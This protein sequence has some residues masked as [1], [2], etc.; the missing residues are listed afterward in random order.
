MDKIHLVMPMAGKGSRFSNKGFSFP[1]PLIEIYNRPFFYWSTQSIRKFV[2]LQSLDFVVLQDH[3][4]QY[5]IDRIIRFYFPEAGVHIL[6]D[7]TEGAVITCLEGIKGI[8]DNYPVVF[9]DCDHMFRCEEFNAFCKKGFDDQVDGLLLTFLSDEDKYS[10]VDKDGT[11]RV[12]GT[13]EKKVISNEAICGCYYFKNKKIFE[14]NAAKYLMHCLYDEYFMSGVYNIMLQSGLQ[15][16]SL[17]TDFHV[18]FGIPEEYE[19]AKD[20]NY[21]LELI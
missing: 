13:V 11:G 9:N 18:S 20:L 2:K 3:I 12:V 17:K 21:Y 8:E 6:P 7:V 10:F 15:V 19:L 4:D 16:K 1:K 5:Q 14:E